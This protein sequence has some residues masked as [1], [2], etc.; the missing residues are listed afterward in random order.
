MSE[1]LHGR[2]S[3]GRADQSLFGERCP[4]DYSYG[5]PIVGKTSSDHAIPSPPTPSTYLSRPVNSCSRS[6]KAWPKSLGTGRFL[7]QALIKP[8]DESA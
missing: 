5:R 3:G 2:P 7:S 8:G 1:R 4:I 6:E